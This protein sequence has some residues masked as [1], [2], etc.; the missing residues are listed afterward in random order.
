M[1]PREMSHY[2]PFYSSG[3]RVHQGCH[4]LGSI[5]CMLWNWIFFPREYQAICECA[6]EILNQMATQTQVSG[7]PVRIPSPC[8]PVSDIEAVLLHNPFVG[9]L[10]VIPK[11]A[12]ERHVGHTACPGQGLRV[13][14]A[15]C[16]GACRE[17]H[18]CGDDWKQQL[19]RELSISLLV[20]AEHQ[21]RNW[22]IFRCQNTT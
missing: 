16:S 17:N 14:P 11:S 2:S 15:L 6:S 12:G 9:S 3:V 5:P 13:G 19:E 21:D 1:E 22:I 18:P 20:A 4:S 8:V 7:E 10:C